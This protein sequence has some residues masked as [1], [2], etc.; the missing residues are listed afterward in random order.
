MS[1]IYT[2]ITPPYHD[3]V[4]GV[5]V[6]SGRLSCHCRPMRGI[7]QVTW[8]LSTNQRF[9]VDI[10]VVTR[11]RDIAL[12]GARGV[13]LWQHAASDRH[14]SM[15]RDNNMQHAALVDIGDN[16]AGEPWRCL[17]S[18]SLSQMSHDL[19]TIVCSVKMILWKLLSCHITLSNNDKSLCCNFQSFYSVFWFSV[20]YWY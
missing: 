9:R 12:Q 4:T 14:C 20:W 5:R 2:I 11:H 18:S 16:R 8:S 7:I 17:C 10:S 13:T 1:N 3:G 6:Q 19:L 15:N